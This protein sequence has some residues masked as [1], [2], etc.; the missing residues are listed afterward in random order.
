MSEK[1]VKPF[2]YEAS[3]RF[4]DHV[5]G[6][7][8]VKVLPGEFYV[9]QEKIALATVLGS[10]VTACIWDPLTKIGG[11]NHF[12]LVDADVGSNKQ[13]DSMRYGVF[14]MNTLIEKLVCAGALKHCLQ[15]K[16]FGG[17]R[18]LSGESNF[19]VG[20]ENNHFVI[21]YLQAQKI[22]VVGQDLGGTTARKVMFF[23]ESGKVMLK[24]ML[25]NTDPEVLASEQHFRYMIRGD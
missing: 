4:Y 18:V 11:M 25:V 3:K 23:P 24:R 21:N 12:M 1:P 9:T 7:D 14:S 5:L 13:A 15:A 2:S 19:R 8:V 17:A 22:P 20:H 6:I 10:C 16:V